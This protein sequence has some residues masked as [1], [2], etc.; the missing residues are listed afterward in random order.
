MKKF[1]K[2]LNL[3]ALTPLI[4]FPIIGVSAILKSANNLNNIEDAT[5]QK[6]DENLF[7]HISDFEANKITYKAN[8]PG[9]MF[10]DK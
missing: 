8:H 1:N 4:T 5:N 7:K 9:T 3:L 10:K 6:P 2:N